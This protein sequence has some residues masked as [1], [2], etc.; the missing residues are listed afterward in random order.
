MTVEENKK[1]A[2]HPV[3]E[4]PIDIPLDNEEEEEEE[5][6]NVNTES[7]QDINP[8][9]ASNAT[10]TEQPISISDIGKSQNTLSES[11]SNVDDDPSKSNQEPPTK[12]IKIESNVSSSNNNNPVEKE[13]S[14]SKS[15]S[16]KRKR[17][18]KGK[19]KY[20]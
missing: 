10:A 4:D 19:R 5:E 9:I 11:V 16:R 20:S 14:K 15:K 12:K 3:Y 7:S 13:R 2:T 6:N 18:R 8:T 1:K 17:Q